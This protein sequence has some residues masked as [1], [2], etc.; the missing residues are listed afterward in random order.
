MAFEVFLALVW[1]S[2]VSS[3]TP[4]P[5][6][7]MLLSSGVNYGFVK[8]IPHMFGVSIGFAVLLACVGFGLGQVLAHFPLGFTIL[9]FLGAAY[10]IYLAYKIAVSGPIQSGDTVGRPMSFIEA[11]LF[12]WVNPKAWVMA[13]TSMAIYTD[14]LNYVPTVL[15]VVFTFMLIN[16]PSVS[17]WAAFGTSMRSFLADPKRLKIFNFIMAM[18]LIASLWPMLR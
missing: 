13:I 3:I 6:N 17:L 18:S 10:L 11:S 16:W 7:L 8:T 1:F 4:G 5:N 2:F 9:K 14:T 12:Q 15:I